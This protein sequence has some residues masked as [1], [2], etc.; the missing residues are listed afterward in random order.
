MGKG[1][2]DPVEKLPISITDVLLRFVEFETAADLKKAVESL[3]NSEFKGAT[4]HC[5]ADV[6]SISLS[7]LQT[8]Y[9]PKGSNKMR[10]LVIVIDLD[11]PLVVEVVMVVMVVPPTTTIVAVPLVATVPGVRSIAIGPQFPV[12]M[13]TMA[14]EIDIARLPGVFAAHQMITHPLEVITAE[15]L[16][17]HHLHLVGTP[18][19]TPIAMIPRSGREPLR[20]LMLAD[21]RTVPVTGR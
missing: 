6:R 7:H 12:V 5:I 3:D 11:H 17:G 13:T 14:A 8:P 10:S 19:R 21:M 15:T 9:S 1:R 2:I 18:S 16:M 20:D 4:V